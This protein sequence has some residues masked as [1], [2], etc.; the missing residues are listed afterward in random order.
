MSNP[1]KIALYAAGIGILYWAITTAQKTLSDWAGKLTYKIL[2][3]G[4]PVINQGKASLPIKV[5]IFNPTPFTAPIDNVKI[6]LSLLRNGMYVPFGKASS[7]V[8]NLEPGNIEKTL[9]AVID[10]AQVIGR[11]STVDSRLTT[12]LNVLSNTQSLADI[13]TEVTVTI[14]G[15]DLPAQ[16]FN[17]KI[18]L[19]DLLRNAAY[20]P[21]IFLGFVATGKRALRSGSEYEK[22]FNLSG[23]LNKE[24]TLLSD[25]NVFETVGE[26]QSIVR[27]TLGQ[28]LRIANALKGAT[29]G[30]TARN[31]WN[32]LYSHVQY[33]KDNP[34]REQLRTP[35]RTWK[36]RK[37]GVDC[38]CY[39]IFIS[40]VLTNL[41]IP[42][43]MR[44]AAY[45]GG[46]Y[47][48]VYVVVPTGQ[49]STVDSGQY[50]TIDP[51][52]DAF[53]KEASFTKKKDFTM[54]VTMLNGP[55]TM[56]N[57]PAPDRNMRFGFNGF[58]ACA[59]N[60]Q[61]QNVAINQPS[62]NI[63]SQQEEAIYYATQEQ[64]DSAIY[65][66]VLQPLDAQTVESGRSTVDKLKASVEMPSLAKVGIGAAAI[67]AAWWLFSRNSGG[68]SL[69]GTK[70]TDRKVQRS[71]RKRLAVAHI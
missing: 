44:I 66:G 63:A 21:K 33:T 18:Y 19:T 24:V 26:M 3:I 22:Y 48:H 2:S 6:S 25:G 4:T 17:Q 7:G 14:K 32:F 65:S 61:S 31:L 13:K 34:L 42:H 35:L 56:L 67:A 8:V 71:P 1:V 16:S 46:E 53:D 29:R 15:V 69:D 64:I 62:K 40:S 37:A 30:E 10:L 45:N 5:V 57:G 59:S 23:V 39:S 50:I 47:Q 54:K 11:Q 12:V 55:V 36:D 58:G 9:Y 51:V 70:N 27:K 38:D 41:G 20:S 68:S 60:T 43:A 52:V 28:T 49:Q